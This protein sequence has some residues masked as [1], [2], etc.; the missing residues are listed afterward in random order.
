ME[1][2]SRSSSFLD[3]DLDFDLL[4]EEDDLL[5][6]EPTRSR[7]GLGGGSGKPQASYK[8]KRLRVT[9]DW[10]RLATAAGVAA[11]ALFVVAFALNAFM[12]HRKAG[13]FRDYFA[14]VGELDKQSSA[15]GEELT[16]LLSQPSG[17]ERAQLVAKL[18]RMQAR[19]EGLQRDAEK[20]SVP[21]ELQNTH[22]WAVTT[23]QLRANGLDAMRRAM[24][25]ALTAKDTKAAATAVAEAAKRLQASDVVD[26]DLFRASGRAVLSREK[27]NDVRIPESTFVTDPE[28][29]SVKAAKLMLERLSTGATNA[30]GEVKVPDDGK[31]RGGQ[32][33]VTTVVPSGQELSTSST[34]EI[35][36]SDDLAFEVT[37]F[38]Q[39][40]VQATQVPV[41]VEIRGDN[42]E[43]VKLT[44]AIDS[45]DPGAEGSVRIPVGDAPTFG[46]VMTVSVSAG[47]VPGE[48]TA[49]NNS[50]T[51]SV[52]FKL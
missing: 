27:V 15:Q 51:Y 42:S 19:A 10:T 47:P 49:G 20:L 14:A 48:K 21:N 23:L 2:T 16:G 18:E 33:Q 22:Q 30:A 11:V 4:L 50:A 35:S 37:F 32:L 6:E 24:A 40:E 45:I 28:F 26:Q 7:V 31:V 39:G 1:G 52:V 46:D 17:A 12:D 8:P 5:Q 25:S 44:G 36:G 13:S 41:V 43:P 9:P 3:D 29:T 38:N 34:T